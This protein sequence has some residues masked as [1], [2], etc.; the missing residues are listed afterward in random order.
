MATVADVDLALR[1]IAVV[2]PPVPPRAVRF[3]QWGI[4]RVTPAG[5]EAG[6]LSD[7]RGVSA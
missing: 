3:V 4:L 5:R 7:L 2:A 1:R 6:R